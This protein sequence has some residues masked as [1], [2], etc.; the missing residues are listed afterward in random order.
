[1]SLENVLQDKTNKKINCKE[2]WY[3]VG[4]FTFS[5]KKIGGLLSVFLS[6]TLEFICNNV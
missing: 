5:I 4:K 6:E 2:K 3:C 1:M